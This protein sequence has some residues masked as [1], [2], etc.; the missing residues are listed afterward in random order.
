M[1]AR[2]GEFC[3]RRRLWVLAAWLVAVII[4]GAAAGPLMMAINSGR[5]HQHTESDDGMRA[6]EESA[7]HGLRFDAIIDGVDPAAPSTKDAVARTAAAV[8]AIDGVRSVD[9]P[10]TA[11]DGSAVS[12]RVTLD[13]LDDPTDAL[14]AS[15]ERMRAL[16]GDLPGSRVRLGGTDLVVEDTNAMSQSD[17]T[18]AELISLPVTLVVLAFI[19][20]GIAGASL[21]VIAAIAA[22]TGSMGLLL[23]ASAF[24]PLDNTV[25]SVVTLLGLG[26][27]IDYGLLLTVRYRDE[28][29]AGHDRATAVRRTW[30]TAG[31]TVLFSGLTVALAL[32]GLF[33][34]PMPRLQAMGAAGIASALVAM[35][36]ALTLTGAMIGI[37]GRFIKPSKKEQ[38]RLAAGGADAERGRFAAIARFTQRRP[39]AVIVATL[40]VLGLAGVPVLTMQLQVPGLRGIPADVESMRVTDELS[41][42]FH[43]SE[44]PPLQVIART[45]AAELDAWAK[46]WATDPAVARVEAARAEDGG[47]ATVAILTKGPDHGEEA[48]AL[49]LRLR[50]DRPAGGGSWVAGNTANRYDLVEGVA[51]GLPPALAVTMLMMIVLLFL[52]TGSLVVPLTAVVLNVVSLSA[53]FGVL[54]LIFQDGWLSGPLHTIT[55]AGLSPYLLVSVFAFA[56]AFSM[57]YGVFLLSR[58]KEYVDAGDAPDVAVRRG[59]QRTGGVITAAAIAML[60]VFAAFGAAQLA[61]LEQV[62]IALFVAVVVDATLVRCLLM[63]A[64]LTVFG[65]WAWWA[66]APLRRLHDRFGI[67]EAP[68]AAPPQPQPV[69]VR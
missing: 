18:M 64:A 27:S 52:L 33:L 43:R 35:L 20:G 49:L 38:R 26:L 21:P 25:L 46:R 19:F 31:R 41:A 30:A 28:L 1:L 9:P 13:K 47:L 4:G 3:F 34:L 67:S 66:P 10:Q 23:G 8:T 62:G 36:A 51:T 53:T 69:G 24:T 39:V 14:A 22:I 17:L 37:L 42:R 6:L 50:A 60:I 63:P 61:D 5:P 65:R 32:P 56:F 7:A 11:V 68:S 16:A 45:G 48:R 12:V 55:M 59:L 2:L 57:D 15:T 29:A 54:V 58:I 44:D 40:A